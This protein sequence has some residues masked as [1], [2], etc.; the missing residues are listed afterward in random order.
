VLTRQSIVAVARDQVEALGFE[1]V[2][3]R[4]VARELGV[5]AP[6]LYD[7]VDSKA[8]LL[9]LVAAEGFDELVKAFA[10][11]SLPTAKERLRARAVAYVSFAAGHPELF[12]LMFQYRPVGVGA[13]IDNELDAA[14][15]AFE[16]SFSDLTQ[17]IS[18]GELPQRDILELS[19]MLWAA[20]HGVATVA[21]MVPSAEHEGLAGD[22]IDAMLKGLRPG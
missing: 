2:S 13:E 15:E 16:A 6:A 7:H 17:A 11:A 20:I 9:E 1:T 4:A 3:L 14:T 21:M 19:M 8:E 10:E 18:E 22:V 12:R 5:T